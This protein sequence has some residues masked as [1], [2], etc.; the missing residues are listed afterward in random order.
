MKNIIKVIFATRF[1][2]LSKHK[3][4]PMTLITL[5]NT[6][7]L[8][9]FICLS[10][11]FSSLNAQYF[12][13]D[14]VNKRYKN[15]V[16]IGLGAS[17]FLGD[18]GGRNQEGTTFL[19]DFEPSQINFAVNV[20]YR[21]NM[22]KYFALRGNFNF[23][24]V[25]GDDALTQ[26]Q[27]RNYRNLRF[28]SNIFEV[29]VIGEWYLYRAR[30]SHIHRLKGP[31]GRKGRNHETYLFAG[32]GGFYFNPKADYN[33]KTYN[34]KDYRTGGQGLEGGPSE[35][36][37]FSVSIPLGI[38]FSYRINRLFKVALEGSYHKTFTDYIDDVSGNYYD[39]E[40]LRSE[41][42]DEAAFLSDP[43]NGDN[44]SWT[45]TGEIR[46]DDTELD[47]FLNL[48]LS[49]QYRI[50]D[51]NGGGRGRSHK[52]KRRRQRAQF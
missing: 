5:N 30:P 13:W 43:S 34:L 35:Y 17:N 41:L 50:Y 47:T 26:E 31:R 6:K 44:P 51:R 29:A 20:A 48:F 32:I 28:K 38:G 11:I 25:S 16:M 37:N 23:S 8:F 18:L 10:F 21:R 22:S 2:I 27:F 45:A 9:L 36:S 14:R 1:F 49:V 7:G 39:K 24:Q 40:A 52:F 12:D 46:G 33:G 3:Y 4:Y 19:M 15:E 42:G